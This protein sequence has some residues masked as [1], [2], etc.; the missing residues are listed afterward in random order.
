MFLTSRRPA[1]LSAA[2]AVLFAAGCGGNSTPA[3]PSTATSSLTSTAEASAFPVTIPHAFGSTEITAAPE[4]VVALGWGSGDA[5]LA[6]GAVPVAVDRQIYG[7]DDDGYMPWFAEALTAVGA[8]KPATLTVGESPAFEEIIAADPDLILATYSGISETDYA[9]LAAIAPTVAYPETP[10]STPWREVITTAGTALGKSTEA[11]DLLADIDGRVAEAAAAHP[12]F[13][14]TTIAAVAVDPAAFYVYTPADPRVQFL[15]DLGFTV[16]PSVTEL[17]TAEASFYY[18]LSLEN[19][20]KLTSDVLLSYAA[21]EE[22]TAEILA[23]PTLA[24][25]PQI[26]AGTVATISGES[27]VSSVSPPTALSLTWGLDDFV[28]ALSAAAAKA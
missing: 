17:D 14:D 4:R 20:D 25:M 3:S 9:K 8:D 23:D 2:A 13:A 18:T 7:A 11:E 12:E 26:A 15:E 19:V 16:A 5:A 21:S 10:W 1:L 6:L 28:S 24:K 27:L 22:R